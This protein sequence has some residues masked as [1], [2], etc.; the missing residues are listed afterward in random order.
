MRTNPK[1]RPRLWRWLAG[2]AALLVVLAGGVDYALLRH[3]LLAGPLMFT[4][5]ACAGRAT[6]GAPTAPR[7]GPSAWTSFE[8]GPTHNEVVNANGAGGSPLQTSWTFQTGG[9]VVMAPSVANGTVYAGSMDGCVYALDAVTGHLL[10][11]FPADNQVMSQPLVANGTVFIGVGNKAFGRTAQG[12][13]VRG[14][15]YS[16]VY[17]LNAANGQVDWYFPT[18]GEVMPTPAYSDGTVY[19][20]TGGGMFYA[21]DATSGRLRWQ[22]GLGSMVSMSSPTI[23][24]DTAVV[25]G[26]NPYRLFGVDLQTHRIAWTQS[27]PHVSGGLDGITPAAAGNTAYVQLAE[28][29]GIKR[30]VELAVNAQ[31][32]QVLWQTR[33]GSDVWNLLQRAV[34]R[35]VLAGYDGEEAGVA[36]A[37]GNRLYVGTPGL[38]QLWA[39]DTRT[40][41]VLWSQHLAQAVR[42]SPL[43][44]GQ[45]L[46][47]TGNS[48]LMTLDT[49]TGKPLVSRIYNRFVEGT[50]IM[51][52]CSTAAPVLL[53]D[54]LLLAGGRGGDTVTAIPVAGAS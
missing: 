49:A 20:A 45:V 53:G 46:Y 6:G 43:V 37:V 15:G 8:G 25:G 44:A 36:T 16:G 24:G 7:L 32:G 19:A 33:L 52:P 10:W 38:P 29:A 48:R 22:V 41:S 17:A 5:V 21:I 28:G 11:S 47:V 12:Q 51:I 34:G 2:G 50:G 54:T 31:T 4:P 40:G 27:F 23:V 14:S 13:L 35:G 9:S 3:H 42:T 30:I 1:T 26:A 18:L 39:L